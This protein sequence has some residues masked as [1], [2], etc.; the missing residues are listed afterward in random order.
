MSG[1]VLRF[2]RFYIENCTCLHVMTCEFKFY[3]NDFIGQMP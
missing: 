2:F 1:D 3:E